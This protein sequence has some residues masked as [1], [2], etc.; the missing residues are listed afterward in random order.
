[1]K[2]LTY[3]KLYIYNYILSIYLFWKSQYYIIKNDYIQNII[4]KIYI[5]KIK[6]YPHGCADQCLVFILKEYIVKNFSFSRFN[7]KL[8]YALLIQWL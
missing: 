3:I 8:N 2:L 5:Y 7:R 4:W 1:M 6:N